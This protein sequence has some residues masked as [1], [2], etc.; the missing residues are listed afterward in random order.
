MLT[1][2]YLVTGSN[3]LTNW[4]C[5]EEEHVQ[6]GRYL[7]YATVS[8]RPAAQFSA[9]LFYTPALPVQHCEPTTYLKKKWR[10]KSFLPSWKCSSTV[11]SAAIC[12]LQS[13]R[14]RGAGSGNSATERPSGT[15]A[16]WRGRRWPP[17]RT[18]SSSALTR[19]SVECCSHSPPCLY[20]RR[21]P[22][23]WL[24]G[25]HRALEAKVRRRVSLCAA[26]LSL[27]DLC[28]LFYHFM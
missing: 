24:N 7:V 6:L 18:Q 20:W 23:P 4:K 16:A 28:W 13:H 14:A 17:S 1:R 3:D 25:T 8:F 19:L 9:S 15:G 5:D 26:G 12:R 27:V 11:T 2:G 22:P 21:D 10:K